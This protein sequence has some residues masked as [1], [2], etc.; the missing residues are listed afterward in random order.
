MFS[1]NPLSLQLIDFGRSID[2]S[3]LPPGTSFTKVVNTDGITCSEMR[4]SKPW[5]EH[6]DYF[7]LAAVAYCLLFQNYIETVKV[8]LGKAEVIELWNSQY[9]NKTCNHSLFRRLMR[10]GRLR[11]ATRDG[12]I[13]ISGDHSSRK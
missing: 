3:L 10:G 11:E 1:S 13:R 4:E 2:M 12:G 6:I 8:R 9:L 5:R 7:G